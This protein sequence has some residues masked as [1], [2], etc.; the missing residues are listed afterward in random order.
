MTTSDDDAWDEDK[1][2]RLLRA[3]VESLRDEQRWRDAV[4]AKHGWPVHPN[5]T[6]TEDDPTRPGGVFTAPSLIQNWT[7]W[8]SQGSYYPCNLL[9]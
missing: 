4:A 6:E 8:V 9:K 1:K 7:T 2:M 5:N 3:V